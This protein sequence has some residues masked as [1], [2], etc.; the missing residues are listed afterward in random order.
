[1]RRVVITGIGALTSLGADNNAFWQSITE[2]RHGISAIEGFDTTDYEVKYAA[3]IKNFDPIAYGIEKKEARRMDRYCQ[4]AMA[5][6]NMAIED[7]GTKF[8]K[9]APFR[10]GVIV[11]SGIGGMGTNSEEH[12]K[13]YEKGPKRISP[14]YVPM[15]IANMAAGMISMHYNFKGSATCITTACATSSDSVGAAFRSIKHG[16][17]DVMIAGGSEAA[18]IPIS[19][20]GF[21]NMMALSTAKNPDRA[22]IPFDK[23][24]DGFVMGDGA[25]VLVLEELEHAKARGAKIYAEVAGYGSTNDAYHITSPDPE[26]E[27]AAMAMKLAMSEAGL[28]PEDIDYINAHGTSTPINDKFETAAIKKA[29]GEH[30]YKTPVSS[31][32]SMTG[33]LLGGAGAVE[34]II[35]ALGLQ[36]GIIPPTAG[37]RVKDEDCDLD[38]VTE[39][40]RKA[41]IQAAL[42]NSLGFG[43]HNATLCLKKFKD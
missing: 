8:E 30:A 26:G 15:I 40:A 32:K 42:S 23:E 7:C 43:G 16:Y 20:A 2:G 38:Y 39:G 29:L 17:H 9:D 12:K 34:A 22:S 24:R 21:H 11:S 18:I 36:N 25:G 41:D 37:F 28:T 3:E 1:M 5:A 27:G 33:H 6:T 19:I 14:L 35:C 10:I 31:T 4:F 13:L